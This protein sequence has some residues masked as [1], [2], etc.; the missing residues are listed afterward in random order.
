MSEQTNI[1]W[2]DS[3][4]NF[5]SGC[6]KVSPGCSNC[7]AEARDRRHMIEPKSHWGPGVARLKHVG[8]VKQAMAMN[9]RPWVCDQTGTFFSEQEKATLTA[10]DG[11]VTFHRRR[12]FSL[13]LGDW[14]DDEVPIEWLAEM[15]DTI[16]QCD[17]VI[18]ILCTKRPEAW[19]NRMEEILNWQMATGEGQHEEIFFEWVEAWIDCLDMPERG[20]I[21]QNIIVLTSVENQAMADKRIPELLKIPAVVRGLSLEPLLGPVEF[22]DVTKRADAVQQLGKKALAG[23]DWLIIGGESGPGARSCNVGWISDLVR[24]GKAAGVAVFV[25]QLGAFVTTHEAT[26]DGWPAGTTLRSNPA[27]TEKCLVDLA[28]KKG[29]DPAEWPVDL[30]VQEWPVV[31]NE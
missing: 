12:I 26:P 3:T 6:S 5:W 29:G 28:D 9:K 7:Y 18:W 31:V 20:D 30:R 4:V 8:A 27:C 1:A 11:A 21:P 22:S 14:L 19:R 16:R 15:L 13:S 17:Q 24:Q 2:C 23:I 25:K 10:H